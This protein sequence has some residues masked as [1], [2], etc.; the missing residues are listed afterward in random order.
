MSEN[1]EIVHLFG[2]LRIK[3]KQDSEAKCM[4]HT[5]VIAPVSLQTKN[6]GMTWMEEGLVEVQV[7][8]EVVAKRARSHPRGKHNKPYN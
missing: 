5:L 1:S 6:L 3:I 2:V 7:T 8:I 4:Q